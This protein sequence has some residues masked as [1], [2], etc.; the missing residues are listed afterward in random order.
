[1]TAVVRLTTG[2]YDILRPS[3]ETLYLHVRYGENSVLNLHLPIEHRD[4]FGDDEN[5]QW[6]DLIV[7][8]CEKF[9]DVYW[10]TTQRTE[11]HL[12]LDWLKD[13]DNSDEM[14]TAWATSM[15]TA[16]RRRRDN[17]QQQMDR[18]GRTLGDIAVAALETSQ[19]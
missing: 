4:Q 2:R 3:E 5:E 9:L 15:Y 18:A 7:R 10:I 1:M 14:L 16:A 11:I 17:A 8:F 12:L 6:A 19:R 13:D